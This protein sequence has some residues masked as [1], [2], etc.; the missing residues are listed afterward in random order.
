M[1]AVIVGGTHEADYLV[2]L[3]KDEHY[4][5]IV[6]NND[7]KWAKYISEKNSIDV[8]KGDPTKKF[9]LEEAKIRGADLFVS[10]S[11]NDIDNFVC[12]MLAKKVFDVKKVVCTVLNPKYVKVFSEL[13]IKGVVS[14]THLLASKILSE[15]SIDNLSQVLSLENG[16][17]AITDVLIKPSSFAV[18]QYLKDL[19][20]PF[21]CSVCAI[22]RNPNV[23]I[24]NGSTMVKANDKVF[25]VV[26]NDQVKGLIEYINH[27]RK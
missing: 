8:F 15:A 26:V 10:I 12:C 13:G 14:S 17:V 27:E 1:K 7:N 21:V 25:F 22:Y 6:I 2:S 20:L 18:N 5:I 16:K 9:V 3:L 23:I 11:N 24:P 19:K 4:Q